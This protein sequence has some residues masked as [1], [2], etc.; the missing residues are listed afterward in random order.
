MN[1]LPKTLTKNQAIAYAVVAFHTL[2]N[3]ANVI[4]ER[5]LAS[6]MVTIMR[7]NK[8]SEIIDRANKILNS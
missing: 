6:E 3:S 8:T 4:D 5:Q 1:E 2:K 7:L